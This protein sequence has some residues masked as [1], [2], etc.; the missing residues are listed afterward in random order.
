MNTILIIDDEEKIWTLLSRILALQ[1]F[2]VFQASDLKSALKKLER[3]EIDVIVCDV[4][5][6][7]GSGTEFSKIFKEK[8][9]ATETILLTAYDNIPDGLH[10]IKNGAFDYITKGDDNNKIIP[11][12]YKAL[13]KVKLNKRVLHSEKQLGNRNSL[14]RI[15]GKSKIIKSAIEDAEK[16]ANIDATF[17]LTGET[18]TGKEV[19]EQAI[20]TVGS[21]SKQN[22]ISINCSAFSK[23]SLQNTLFGHKSGARKD[24]KVIFEQANNGTV[25]LDELGEKPLDLQAKF[26][27]KRI[28]KIRN[29]TEGKVKNLIS[30]NC[31]EEN[32]IVFAPQKVNV[33]KLNV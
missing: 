8:H 19:F 10:A 11:L 32:V 2:K 13:E 14:E 31:A 25:F 23:E 17:L 30:E 21:R 27:V 5:L 9:P 24:S 3:T 26:Q 12:I 15:I 28:A 22:F 6:P 16:V 29:I 4:K 33:L 7:D 1:G 20:H 18:G